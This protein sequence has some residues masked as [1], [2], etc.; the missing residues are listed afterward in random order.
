MHNAVLLHEENSRLRAEN[1]RQKRKRQQRRAFIQTGGSITIGEGVATSER[2]KA[3]KAKAPKA[4]KA[5][6]AQEARVE[7]RGGEETTA[8]ASEPTARKR[9]PPKCSMCNSTEHTARSCP[10]K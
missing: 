4:P 10:S 8:E 3:P 5:P 2:Q 6:K 1:A 7:A 9:A